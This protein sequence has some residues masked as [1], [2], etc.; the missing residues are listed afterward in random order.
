MLSDEEEQFR[1]SLSH[2]NCLARL[3]VKDMEDRLVLLRIEADFEEH[4]YFRHWPMQI[5]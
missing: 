1:F 4:L 3:K 5:I 2:E